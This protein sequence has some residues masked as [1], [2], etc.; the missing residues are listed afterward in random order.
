M[1]GFRPNASALAALQQTGCIPDHPVRN[2]KQ[3][4]PVFT[5]NT[6]QK[7]SRTKTRFEIAA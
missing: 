2:V 7:E 6:Q 3:L 4:K 5:A 1:E